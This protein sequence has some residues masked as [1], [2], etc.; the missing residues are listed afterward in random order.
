MGVVL[1]GVL[2]V[3]TLLLVKEKKI[4][5]LSSLLQKEFLSSFIP[6]G[7]LTSLAL[8]AFFYSLQSI[9]VVITNSI[10]STEPMFIFLISYLFL[11]KEEVI[12]PTIVL[13]SA[14]IMAGVVMI[15]LF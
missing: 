15:I 5:T 10:E 1:S 7:F 9:P 3:I 8:Y 4:P 14:T 13:S 2:L 6:G 12:T 11:Q